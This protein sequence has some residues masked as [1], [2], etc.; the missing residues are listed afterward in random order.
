MSNAHPVSDLAVL[1]Q[2]SM[3]SREIAAMVG[4]RLAERGVIRLPP[5]ADSEIINNLGLPQSVSEFVF[6]G[7]QGKRDSIVVVAQLSPAFTA[8]LVDRWQE[9]MKALAED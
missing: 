8:R 2:A 9:I 4:S 6:R 5:M 7:E 1:H 3:S